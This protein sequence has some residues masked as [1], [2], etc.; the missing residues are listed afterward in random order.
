VS[1]WEYTDPGDSL[2][3]HLGE[4]GCDP[5]EPRIQH[6]ARLWSGIQDLPRHLGQ[7][8]GGMV[9][10]QGR[11]DGVVPLEPATMPGRSVVQWTRTTAPRSASSRWISWGSA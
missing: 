11:L 9:I 5:A 2:L 6:F 10:A 3:A 4:A 1:N 8:S 7:H